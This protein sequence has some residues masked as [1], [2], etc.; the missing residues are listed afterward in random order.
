MEKVSVGEFK[1]N[2]SEIIEKVAK[3]K[4]FEVTYGKKKKVIGCFVPKETEDKPNRK[5][6]IWKEEMN[7]KW[8]G[9]GKITLKEFL[10]QA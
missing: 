3:G 9:D 1:A 2:F 8:A 6:G 5:L 7:L 10:E 4:K